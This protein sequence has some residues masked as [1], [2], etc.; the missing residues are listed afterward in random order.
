M[1]ARRSFLKKSLLAMAGLSCLPAIAT[2]ADAGNAGMDTLTAIRTRRSVREYSEKPVSDKDIE[3]L[4]RAAMAAPSANNTQPWEFVVIK[5]R[6]K[7]QEA[8]EKT[9]FP[10]L[11]KSAPLAILTCVDTKLEGLKDSGVLALSA[12]TQNLL[13]AA[14]ASGLG[15]VWTASYPREERMQKMRN[16]LGLPEHIIPM[17]LVVIGH[18]KEVP[19][20]VDRFNPARVHNEKW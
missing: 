17:A 19:A 15:A 11:A 6:E 4:L 13:L 18:P 9:V 12:C 16:F 5:S 2:A 10:A 3:L 7:I 14:H 8:V 1:R 20:P